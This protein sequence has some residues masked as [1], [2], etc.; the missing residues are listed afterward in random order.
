MFS[1]GRDNH[2]AVE[3]IHLAPD[4][5]DVQVLGCGWIRLDGDGIG[6]NLQQ[7]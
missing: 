4:G 2:F 5:V 1:Q 7:R 6:H 3:H